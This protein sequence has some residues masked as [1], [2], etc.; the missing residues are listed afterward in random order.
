MKAMKFA[1]E[2]WRRSDSLTL[3]CEVIGAG[4]AVTAIQVEGA[5]IG[6]AEDD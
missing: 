5:G 6:P 4:V 1:R 2:T 3:S